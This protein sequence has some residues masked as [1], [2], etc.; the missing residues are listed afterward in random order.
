MRR[1]SE[2]EEA[3]LAGLAHEIDRQLRAIREILRKP[4]EA[5]FARG[6]LT[7]PQR[8]IMQILV[9]SPHG[10]S[11]KELSKQAGLAHSTVS[12]IVDR[13]EKRGMVQREQDHVDGRFSKIKISEEVH[14]Y[15]RD[16]LP[17]L[18]VHPLIEALREAE[19]KERKAIV[20]GLRMLRRLVEA[21]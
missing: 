18:I 20:R 17:R 5:D 13:L 6:E 15:L 10:L 9:H 21:E 1:R 14:T 3:E 7:G 12:G 11:L 4:V 2:G 16:T 19:P 8:N